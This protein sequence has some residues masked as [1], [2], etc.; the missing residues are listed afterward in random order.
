MSKYTK[1]ERATIAA[2]L[3]DFFWQNRGYVLTDE[4]YGLVKTLSD[5][6]RADSVRSWPLA[7][8]DLIEDG[9]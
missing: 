6:A 1:E 8:A 3:R 7:M 5:I 9:D 4:E 2:E